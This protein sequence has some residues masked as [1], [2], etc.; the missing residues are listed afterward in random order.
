MAI[1]GD[2]NESAETRTLVECVC[3]KTAAACSVAIC[4][5]CEDAGVCFASLR[6]D[7]AGIAAGKR[8]GGMRCGRRSGGAR[9]PEPGGQRGGALG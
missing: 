4:S 6:V 5:S 3:C 1:G 9:C 8:R 2:V 7:A